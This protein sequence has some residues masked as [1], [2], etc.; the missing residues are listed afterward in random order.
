LIADYLSGD[1]YRKFA[2]DSLGILNPTEQ[3][4]QVYKAVVLG[5]IYGKGAASLAR[6][7]GISK[8]QAITIIDEMQARYPVLEAWLK[9]ITTK[10]AHCVPIV[11]TLGWS[12]TATGIPGEER[13]FLNFPMQGNGSELLRLVIVRASHLPIIGCAHDSFMVEAP[14]D[15][16]EA[17]VAE[18]QAIMRQAS[19]DLLG[20]E[21]RADCKPAEIVRYPHRF[22]DKREREDGM[23]HWR[24][25]MRLIEENVDGF[26]DRRHG[27]PALDGEEKET[28]QAKANGF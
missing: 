24:W 19:R 12:L 14:I 13:T 26:T 16:I 4:R 2:A 1:V 17:V 8:S 23:Q 5:R 3:Q 15:Q 28:A 20:F 18:L 25:L 22:I 6:D 27:D 21:L 7:L 9:R 10:A 11:C